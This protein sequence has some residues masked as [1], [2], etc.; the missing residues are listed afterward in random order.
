MKQ[1]LDSRSTVQANRYFHTSCT[2]RL[3][4]RLDIPPNTETK[5][6]C[7]GRFVPR[8][9]NKAANSFVDFVED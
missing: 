5:S 3:G 6:S 2:G 8:L 9:R 1:E 4:P 7:K